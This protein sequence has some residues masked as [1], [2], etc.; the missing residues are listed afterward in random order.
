MMSSLVPSI[1]IWLLVLIAWHLGDM[2]YFASD[3]IMKCI[4]TALYPWR[5]IILC[6]ETTHYGAS[7]MAA[8]IT[9]KQGGNWEPGS[10]PPSLAGCDG[11]HCC[12]FGGPNWTPTFASII[13]PLFFS[14]STPASRGWCGWW[15]KAWRRGERIRN[16]CA[17]RWHRDI[18][19]TCYDSGSKSRAAVPVFRLWKEF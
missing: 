18:V 3:V 19:A 5:E 11:Q 12:Y 2:S 14:I 7:A 6:L 8:R 13:L 16:G 1:V 9:V 4:I 10:S 17:H 15:R